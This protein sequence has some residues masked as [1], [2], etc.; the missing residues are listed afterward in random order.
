MLPESWRDAI[1]IFRCKSSSV[2]LAAR[3]S[4]SE[5]LTLAPNKKTGLPQPAWGRSAAKRPANSGYRLIC[6]RG[7]DEQQ[8]AHEVEPAAGDDHQVPHGVVVCAAV[9]V[10]PEPQADEVAHD[11]ANHPR[12]A[13]ESDHRQNGWNGNQLDTAEN[14]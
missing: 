6:L 11:A 3:Y 13:C 7:G 4:G 5:P 14:Y 9:V 12:Q 1:Q 8:D 10:H 2:P